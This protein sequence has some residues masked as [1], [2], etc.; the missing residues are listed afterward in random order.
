MVNALSAKRPNLPESVQTLGRLPELQAAARAFSEAR[1]AVVLFGSEGTGLAASQALAQACANLL[2][3]TGHA[4][5]PNNGLLGVW[6][7]AN[8]QGAWDMGFRP[9]PDLGA[10][11]KSARALYI[12]AADPA[13]D[14]PELA[15]TGEFMV[16]Q[17]L[18][19][20][21]TARLADV[22]LPAQAF[23]EREGS[24]TSG[25]RRVQ[26]FY[27][28]VPGLQGVKAD[29]SITAQIGQLLGLNLEGQLPSKVMAR[30]AGRLPDYAG[31]SYT[32]L[33]RSTEQ[34]PIVGR[35][36]LYYGGTT[37]ENKQGLGVQLAPAAQ[38]GESVSLGWPH[39][40]EIKIAEGSLL[41]APFTRL[42]DRGR[43]VLPSK[44]LHQRI[45]QPYVV[46]HPS[47]AKELG[48]F[49][50]DMVQ[51]TLSGSTNVVAARL[52]KSLPAGVVLV[53]RS[54]GLPIAGPLGVQVR[55]VERVAV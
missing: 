15:E 28:A 19:L 34:W 29:F 37:Y 5:R 46:L 38:R 22:V 40:P 3:A 39:W 44:L 33:A 14:D 4:G 7:R 9:L 27:P 50:G 11:M 21:D 45:G 1:E 47:N 31:L 12:V 26:R 51:V 17:D 55:A 8:E 53:P 48:I 20:T 24:Y 32:E 52:D 16:V 23:N 42:Y 30:I 6:S 43:T 10:A 36:E 41:A 18:F 2:I 54:M 13:G 25:E 49:E 35:G